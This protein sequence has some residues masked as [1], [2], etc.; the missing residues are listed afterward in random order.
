[1]NKTT[2]KKMYLTNRKKL[3]SEHQ[4]LEM[5]RLK[6]NKELRQVKKDMYNLDKTLFLED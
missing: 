3:V 5:A 1:M 2:M 4:K 6:T